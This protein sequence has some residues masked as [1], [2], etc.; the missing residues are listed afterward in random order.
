MPPS[1]H[2]TLDRVF[3]VISRF[4]CGIALY[5]KNIAGYANPTGGLPAEASNPQRSRL[6]NAVEQHQR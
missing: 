4:Q 3:S 2:A 6:K 5:Q 1:G